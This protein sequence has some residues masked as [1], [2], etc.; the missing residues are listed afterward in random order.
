MED[1]NPTRVLK[2]LRDKF[3][4]LMPG[5]GLEVYQDE[6]TP[7]TPRILVN[8][9]VDGRLVFSMRLHENGSVHFVGELNQSTA[10]YG[11]LYRATQY[12]TACPYNPEQVMYMLL[13]GAAPA[14]SSYIKG[15]DY[16]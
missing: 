4:P 9:K 1:S 11:D 7:D 8:S 10:K 2:R 15:D 3:R 14:L 5:Y 13:I 16:E 6:R 12:D